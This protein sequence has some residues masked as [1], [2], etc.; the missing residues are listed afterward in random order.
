MSHRGRTY[1]RVH[2]RRQ[3]YRKHKIVLSMGFDVRCPGKLSKG[4]VHCSC[5]LCACKST[6]DRGKHTNS[7]RMYSASDLRKFDALT[8]RL[9]EV[10]EDV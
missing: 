2:R 6:A 8:Y 9:K 5:P 4:K 1:S 7:H 3:I 10:K